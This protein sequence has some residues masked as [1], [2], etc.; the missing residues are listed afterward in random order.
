MPIGP[1]APMGS[2]L[3]NSLPHSKT[4]AAQTVL[5]HKHKWSGTNPPARLAR[6]AS[7]SL[8]RRPR[9]GHRLLPVAHI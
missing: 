5:R 8:R 1:A 7:R 3:G 9:P 2:N 6:A 4:L